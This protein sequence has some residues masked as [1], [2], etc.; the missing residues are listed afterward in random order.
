MKKKTIR[1]IVNPFSGVSDK[2][3]IHTQ[4]K[5]SL[6][7]DLFEYEVVMTEAPMHAREL[8]MDAVSIGMDIVAAVGGDGT[9]N[10]IAKPL[11]YSDTSLAILPG[12][13]G[14]GFA[15]H[16]GLGR[17]ISKAI[18]FL[19]QGQA[20]SIDTCRLNDLFYINMAGV[21]FD[22]TVAYH[23][24]E[25]SARGFSV[26]FNQS[27]R[28]A[29]KYQNKTYKVTIDDRVIKEKF[30]SINVANASMFGYNFT[31][32]PFANLQDGVLDLVMIKDA[33][34]IKYIFD[35]W[36]FLNK[37]V[38]KIPYVDIIKVKKVKIECEEEMHFHIDGEGNISDGNITFEVVPHSLKLWMPGHHIT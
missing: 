23:T 8:A 11:L 22:A 2:K 16:L 30:L 26:Y 24:K 1:F 25:K 31:I 17:N 33:H 34:K 32:A 15:M 14:N 18:S 6:N 12:G 20:N 9:I 7:H 21:G 35:V 28:E 29:L 27:F 36:R 10:E 4:I 13:S 38:H 37:S 5:E 19:N 3:N